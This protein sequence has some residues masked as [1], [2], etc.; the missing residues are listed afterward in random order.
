MGLSESVSISKLKSMEL[1]WFAIDEASEIPKEQFLLFQSR[2]RRILPGGS[3]PSYFGILASNPEDCWL[4][5][6][7]VLGKGGGDYAYFPSLPKDNPYLP[8]DYVD[9]LRE[10]IS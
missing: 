6:D 2:L 7:F 1:G 8:E 4:K 9:R 5:D 3:R 10:N